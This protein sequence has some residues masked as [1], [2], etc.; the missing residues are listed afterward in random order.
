MRMQNSVCMCLFIRDS[1]QLNLAKRLN[2]AF[3]TFLL[4]SRCQK[5]YMSEDTRAIITLGCKTA[6]RV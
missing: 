2:S 4:V 5:S 6:I 1:K 3:F